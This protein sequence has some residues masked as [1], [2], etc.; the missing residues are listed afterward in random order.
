MAVVTYIEHDGAEHKVDV[1]DGDSVMQ[2]ALNNGVEGIVGECG[3]GL[4][5]ATCHCYVDESWIDRTGTPSQEETE[6]LE[7][8]SA[9]I[10]ANSRLSCQLFVSDALD[11]LVVRLPESQY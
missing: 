1:A 7:A 10:K 2:G 8:A 3:G 5:C 9:E 4:A 6:M 11:G